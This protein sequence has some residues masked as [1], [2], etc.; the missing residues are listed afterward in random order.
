MKALFIALAFLLLDANT[1]TVP[2]AGAE[3]YV[4]HFPYKINLFVS[5]NGTPADVADDFVFD[6]DF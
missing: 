5:D 3:M 6:F 4:V 2:G 1:P